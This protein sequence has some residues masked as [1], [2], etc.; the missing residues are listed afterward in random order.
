MKPLDPH[1]LAHEVRAAQ[2]LPADG[3]DALPEIRRV[4]RLVRAAMAPDV[5]TYDV[6]SVQGVG[7]DEWCYCDAFGSLC[8]WTQSVEINTRLALAAVATDDDDDTDHVARLLERL[9]DKWALEPP[10]VTHPPRK[11]WYPPGGN[12]GHLVA[13]DQVLRAFD[14]DP[15]WVLKPHPITSDED[16][17]EAVRAFGVSRVLPRQVSGY[18]LLRRAEVV[19]YTT[20]SEMGIVAMMHGTDAVDFTA[21]AQEHRGRLYSLYRAIRESGDSPR[22]ALNRLVRCPWSGVIPL[23]ESDDGVTHRARAFKGRSIELRERFRPLVPRSEF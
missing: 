17:R 14:S 21:Y 16:V 22:A 5:P 13:T 19:G 20:T 4:E 10:D 11:V 2:G 1:G 8:L 15:A 18:D 12:L 3:R 9:G 23:Y 6:C 7:F